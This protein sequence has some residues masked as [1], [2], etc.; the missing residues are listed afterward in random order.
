MSTEQDEQL[1]VCEAFLSVVDF[2][3]DDVSYWTYAK[4]VTGEERQA[5]IEFL[6]L[7]K[8]GKARISDWN[9]PKPEPLRDISYEEFMDMIGDEKDDLIEN[10]RSYM[11]VL[12]GD[13]I[14]RAHI[15]REAQVR[16][17]Y[18]G[19]A[20]N[21]K[22]TGELHIQHMLRYEMTY[23]E[24]LLYRGCK[25]REDF[26]E[27]AKDVSVAIRRIKDERS[28]YIDTN[29]YLLDPNF[30]YLTPFLE[31]KCDYSY[32]E[33]SRSYHPQL[34]FAINDIYL[35]FIAVDDAYLI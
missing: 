17:A 35:T 33:F 7:V 31:F 15:P 3:K 14:E 5:Y 26:I 12:P 25:T 1:K 2:E 21:P 6:K 24:K 11:K 29:E 27:R 8:D 9:Y 23:A 30:I 28:Q 16:S 22:F 4:T 34:R 19:T 13:V 10:Y 32:V 18:I 20:L